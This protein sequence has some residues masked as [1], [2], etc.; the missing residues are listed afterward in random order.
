MWCCVC[1]KQLEWELKSKWLL[2]ARK[3]GG[4]CTNVIKH[5]AIFLPVPHRSRLVWLPITLQDTLRHPAWV[6]TEWPVQPLELPLI[7]SVVT[8]VFTEGWKGRTEGRFLLNVIRI[9][10]M[11]GCAYSNEGSTG[12]AAVCRGVLPAEPLSCC[13]VITLP[14]VCCLP[15][16]SLLGFM[17]CKSIGVFVY[18]SA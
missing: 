1:C 16:I 13:C 2:A 15:I 10:E 4:A 6:S 14:W 9:Y 11:C 17:S 8:P 5:I 18:L 3:F 12:E 7:C